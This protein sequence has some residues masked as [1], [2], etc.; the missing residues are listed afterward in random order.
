MKKTI[1]TMLVAIGLVCFSQAQTTSA[2]IVGYAKVTATGGELSLV[3][4]NFTPSSTLVADIIGDQ[5]PNNSA[6]HIWD[7]SSGAYQTIN[8][9]A[10]GGW[11]SAT[12]DL[13]DAFW[14]QASGTD[15]N[16]IILSGDVNTA[17]TNSTT[18]SAGIEATGL[19]F[20]VETTFG[21]TDLAEDLPTNSAIHIWDSATQSYSTYNKTARGGWGSANNVVVGPTT[22]FWVQIANSL[23]WDEA[24]PFN[25]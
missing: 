24:R 4:L 9:T 22:G 23:N 7:K 5:L 10:R 18:I 17:A 2:N 8:K 14:I 6:I 16:E 1:L 15:A 11:G 25:F 3:A 20:P 13:G 12:L 19:F 21:A